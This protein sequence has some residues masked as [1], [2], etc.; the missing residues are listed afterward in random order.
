MEFY[1]H[2]LAKIGVRGIIGRRVQN[3]KKN[4]DSFLEVNG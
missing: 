3:Q 1:N 4:E 2:V